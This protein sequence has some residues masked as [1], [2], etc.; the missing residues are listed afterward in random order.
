MMNGDVKKGPAS[1]NN[2]AY[3]C[4][5]IS[6]PRNLGFR[7]FRVFTYA[8]LKT[9]PRSQD[10]ALTIAE[11]HSLT[12]FYDPC[13]IP[14]S[15]SVQHT[16]SSRVPR[17]QPQSTSIILAPCGKCSVIFLHT[18]AQVHPCFFLQIHIHAVCRTHSQLWVWKGG[19][20]HRKE[21]D[22]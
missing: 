15:N 20:L 8:F 18:S 3:T 11:P 9:A 13:L 22:Q 19:H 2:V 5:V 12:L 6:H 21:K 17:L 4:M 10:W 1:R 14:T 16:C 7:V